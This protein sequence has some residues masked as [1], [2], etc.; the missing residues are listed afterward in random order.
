M[1]IL[2]WIPLRRGRHGAHGTRA[3]H[4]SHRTHGPRGTHRTPGHRAAIGIALGLALFLGPGLAR[5]HEP[6][7]TFSIVGCD[8]ETGEVGVA[9]QSKF[10]AVGAVVP[11]AKA[12]VGAVATQ[13]FANTTFGPRGLE[14][15]ANGTS[16]SEVLEILLSTDDGRDQRQVGIVDARGRAAAHTGSEC[17]VWAG[18]VTG[19]NFT[20]QG[21]ILVG[22]E[23]VQAM[24]AAFRDT[25]GMLGEKLMRALE[26]GQAAGG[27][28][29]GQQSAAILIAKKD[30][31]YAGFDDRYCD[32]RVDDHQEPIRELRR[33]FGL[34][35]VNA[36][37]QS[38]YVA[39][40]KGDFDAAYRDGKEAAEL[41]PRTGE[42]NFHLAC[43]YSRGGRTEDALEQLTLAVARDAS[44]AAR[45]TT[46]T[47]L[48]PLRE[49]P[50]FDAL[51]H[52][53][54]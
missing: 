14:L 52:S 40:E 38:G 53:A 23:T 46:D 5:A 33:V 29:R 31:G 51:T 18:H 43:Y 32:L 4:G 36:L 37:I 16:P 19:E 26:A 12:E 22:E 24:A 49:D 7:A 10:F 47:D 15:L 21:N 35:K 39:V 13:A 54:R 28:S 8:P 27:D 2:P 30:S 17:M 45:A 11:W 25:E 41:D 6:V 3:T 1:Q 50:R 48:A 9:V 42:P 20:A 34:W 44:L